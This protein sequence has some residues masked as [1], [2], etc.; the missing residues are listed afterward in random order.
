MG[1]ADKHAEEMSKGIAEHFRFIKVT[2]DSVGDTLTEE[3]GLKL[4]ETSV[5]QLRALI[6]F[7]DGLLKDF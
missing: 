5:A 2:A 6:P 1:K 4:I 3:E 7:R